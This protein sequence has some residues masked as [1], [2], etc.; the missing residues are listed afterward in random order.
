LS[1]CKHFFDTRSQFGPPLQ[2]RVRAE[3]ELQ[4]RNKNMH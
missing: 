2:K 3:E 4:K 1:R